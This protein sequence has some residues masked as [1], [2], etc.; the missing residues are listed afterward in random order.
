MTVFEFNVNL[1]IDETIIRRSYN[2]SLSQLS[3][4]PEKVTGWLFV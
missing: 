4:L 2:A 1:M 3:F